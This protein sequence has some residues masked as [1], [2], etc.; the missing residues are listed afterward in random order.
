MI[1]FKKIAAWAYL[2]YAMTTIYLPKIK[3]GFIGSGIHLFEVVC[4]LLSFYIL[5]SGKLKFT[6]LE[7]SYFLYIG[8][9]FFS[10]GIGCLT[11]DWINARG[12]LLLIKYSSFVLLVPIAFYF[13]D[14]F[15]E[16]TA[17]KILASQILFIVLV[18]G[19]VIYH[20]IFQPVGIDWM[21]AGYDQRYRIIG[22]TGKALTSHGLVHIGTTSV[23]MGVYIGILFLIF[24]SLYLNLNQWKYLVIAFILFVAEMLTYTRSGLAVI[25]VGLIYLF[26]VYFLK[27]RV[28]KLALWMGF[29][30]V[31]F[32][33]AG[34]F[35]RF[36]IF[37]KLQFMGSGFSM[38]FR[39]WEVAFD[40]LSKHPLNLI[41][42]V[43]YDYLEKVMGVYTTESLLFDTLLMSGIFALAFLL[44]FF[45]Y[46]WRYASIAS[47]PFPSNDVSKA[48]LF[49]YKLS[50]PGILLACIVGGNS[51]QTDFTAPVLYLLFGVCLSQVIK[52]QEVS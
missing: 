9:S 12:F 5:L 26:T 6:P 47:R 51:I 33:L 41:F 50:L 10:W 37:A 32:Y 16:S 4:V 44:L 39:Y 52:K 46:F 7:K 2:L 11:T 20:T 42:G 21:S 30:V 28:L 8:F 40:Y 36:G 13:K 49:G 15:N 34:F 22:F 38:R 25:L 45:Y 31:L 48:I 1:N 29:F 14:Y 27:K 23:P 35:T 18:G 43:G 24:L 3:I 19:F 17:K